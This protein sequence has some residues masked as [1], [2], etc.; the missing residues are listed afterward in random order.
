MDGYRPKKEGNP[1][2]ITLALKAR[3]DPSESVTLSRQVRAT[4]KRSGIQAWTWRDKFSNTST[5]I[6]GPRGSRGKNGSLA[7]SLNAS[8]WFP[9]LDNLW[10]DNIDSSCLNTVCCSKTCSLSW[11]LQKEFNWSFFFLKD[12]AIDW[13]TTNS[14]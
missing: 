1:R 5:A 13:W 8:T 2:D 7:T 3:I 9:S 12:Y 10:I 14:S 11:W 4:F 6:S